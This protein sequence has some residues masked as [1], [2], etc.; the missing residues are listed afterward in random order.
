MMTMPA[1][2]H[3]MMADGDSESCVACDMGS[4]LCRHLI[5]EVS[6]VQRE[7]FKFSMFRNS[8]Q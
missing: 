8:F 4:G 6:R 5:L 3:L 1:E 2:S 7:F